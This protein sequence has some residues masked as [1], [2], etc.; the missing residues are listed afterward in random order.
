MPVWQQL[1]D[2]YL[3]RG[4]EILSVAVDAQGP[5][6]PRRFSADAGAEFTT[7]VDEENL[8]G[9]LYGFKAVP[10]GFSIDEKGIVRYRRLGGFDIRTPETYALVDG[11]ANG[12]EVSLS[13]ENSGNLLGPDFS[14][15]NRYFARGLALYR[16]GGVSEALDEWRKG[17][18]LVPDNYIIRKQ[19]WAV[20]NPERFYSGSVD[21]DWQDEQIELGR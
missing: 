5:Q 14:E 3:E 4:L 12:Q 10:N 8:L 9:R 13:P 6:K 2:S 18:T 15:A 7:V 19:I 21:Y 17:T 16:T 1:Y 20:E 11:W